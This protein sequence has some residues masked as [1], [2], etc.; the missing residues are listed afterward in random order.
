MPVSRDTMYWGVFWLSEGDEPDELES[1][2]STGDSA[3]LRQA[4]LAVEHERGWH[5]DTEVRP[6]LSS[7]LPELSGIAA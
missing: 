3:R 1:T 7:E 2:H 6:V 5:T 4:R